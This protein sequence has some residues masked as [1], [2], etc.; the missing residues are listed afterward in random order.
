M[1]LSGL[2]KMQRGFFKTAGTA[3]VVISLAATA[4]AETLADAM[5]GAYQHS[6]LIE[7]NRALLRAAD[8]DVAIA[9]SKLRPIVAWSSDVTR[10][11]SRSRSENFLSGRQTITERRS[12]QASIG[13]SAEL[14]LYDGGGSRMGVDVAKENVLATREVL[15][16]VEQRVLLNAVEAYMNVRSETEN[17]AL[18]RNNL[19]VINEELRAARDRFDVGEVTRT[20]VAQTEARLASARS[21]LAVSQGNLA[22]A[23]EYYRAVVG[24]KPGNLARPPRVPAVAKSVDQAKAIAIQNHPEMRKAQHDAAVGDLNVLIARAAMGPQIKL[25]GRYGL[26]ETFRDDDFTSAGQ[27]AVESVQP[28]YQGGRLSALERKARASRDASRSAL[29]IA[30]HEINRSV[31]N[32]YAMLE[33]ARAAR[34]ASEKQ[35]R[36]SRV[37]FRGVREEATLGARTTLDVLNAEQELL[38]AQANLIAATSN[39]YFAAYSLLASTGQLTAKALNLNVKLYDPTA[40]YNLVKDAPTVN[41][42]QG[43]KLDRVIRALGKE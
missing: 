11:Y 22:Q 24:H 13:I 43:R 9:I 34:V 4:R 18:R 28:I 17:V 35:I 10:S 36:A 6:G 29:H 16:S 21:A 1:N 39:E 20:D 3:V 15:R 27:I 32:A 33:V 14:L 41:S 42:K 40:Y 5:A 31:G 2:K 38:D 7:Q 30:R 25:T 37:A 12:T 26:S 19:R 23:V 8:E